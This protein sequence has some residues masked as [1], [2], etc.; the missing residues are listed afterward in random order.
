[1]TQL[2]TRCRSRLWAQ[3]LHQKPLKIPSNKA[4]INPSPHRP[5][6]LSIEAT[7]KSYFGINFDRQGMFF[8]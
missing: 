7:I 4:A 8:R 5:N 6:Q 3:L 1:M 2:V